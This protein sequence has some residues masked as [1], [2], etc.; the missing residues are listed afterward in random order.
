MVSTSVLYRD[1]YLDHS[2]PSAGGAGEPHTDF[3]PARLHRSLHN[4]LG[5]NHLPAARQPAW[6]LQLR[7][8]VGPLIPRIDGSRGGTRSEDRVGYSGRGRLSSIARRA[9]S[10]ERRVGKE[11]RVARG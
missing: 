11:G 4:S 5:K 7:R 2:I 3:L 6:A 9:R 10:E 8:S 1:R